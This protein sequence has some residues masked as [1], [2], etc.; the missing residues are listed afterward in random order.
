MK[1]DS[2]NRSI[3]KGAHV[4]N[5]VEIR[6][7][8]IQLTQFLRTKK[9]CKILS[10]H[11]ETIEAD[12][13]NSIR[14]ALSRLVNTTEHRV[15]QALVAIPRSSAIVKYF[16]F[17]T[18]VLKEL[19]NMLFL[20][21]T[22]DMPLPLDQM[23]VSYEVI[24][25]DTASSFVVAYIVKK[26]LI[27]TYKAFLQEIGVELVQMTISSYGLFAWVTG[28]AGVLVDKYPVIGVL[29]VSYAG[30]EIIICNKHRLIF[31]RS[32][33]FDRLH[34]QEASLYANGRGQKKIVVDFVTDSLSFY[35]KK[36]QSKQIQLLVLPNSNKNLE[37]LR[38]V[39]IENAGVYIELIDTSIRF[40]EIRNVCDDKQDTM[41]SKK[42]IDRLRQKL[43]KELR[44]AVDVVDSSEY[45]AE[46]NILK[47][48]F[49]YHSIGISCASTIGLMLSKE[50]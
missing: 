28:V 12:N 30:L 44:L 14:S 23:S 22:K 31:S 17:P 39:L 42:G 6:D 50:S 5:I 19:E 43:E 46:D 35:Q 37:D 10:M 47:D 13:E 3:K 1:K 29:D 24:D 2:P 32:M 26:P 16:R 25:Q 33:S 36:V 48:S 7:S 8:Y 34:T 27:E 41:S 11:R 49:E 38:D 9:E 4:K 40:P 20:Q 45:F 15:T 18:I 21:L